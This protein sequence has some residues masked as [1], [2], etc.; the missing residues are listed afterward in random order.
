[1]TRVNQ[2]KA[3]FVVWFELTL[4]GTFIAWWWELVGVAWGHVASAMWIMSLSGMPRHDAGY[5]VSLGRVTIMTSWEGA[6]AESVER[7]PRMREIMGSVNG[8]VKPLTYKLSWVPTYVVHTYGKFIVDTSRRPDH[9]QADLISHSVTLF[10]HWATWS[11]SYSNN[12][13]HMARQRYVSIFKSLVWL[14]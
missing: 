9:Q 11:L 14:D 6:V 13:N 5:L 2:T 8:Q 7:R 10:C 4:V 12:I 1:M 3:L